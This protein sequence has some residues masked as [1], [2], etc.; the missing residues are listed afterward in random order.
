MPLNRSEFLQFPTLLQVSF[1][2][3]P[4]TTHQA[5]FFPLASH[6]I[7]LTILQPS[8]TVSLMPAKLPLPLRPK[9]KVTCLKPSLL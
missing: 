9:A 8:L 7:F 5:S 6:T 1:A 3:L 4:T 2:K